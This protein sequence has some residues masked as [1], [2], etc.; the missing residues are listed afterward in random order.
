[1]QTIGKA[2]NKMD[3]PLN[4]TDI[5]LKSISGKTNYTIDVKIGTKRIAS[6]QDLRDITKKRRKQSNPTRISSNEENTKN[7]SDK[8]ISLSTKNKSELN[9]SEEATDLKL[10]Y[11]QYP[12]ASLPLN[13][14]ITENQKFSPIEIQNIHFS[15]DI[16]LKNNSSTEISNNPNSLQGTFLKEISHNYKKDYST[17]SLTCMM[18]FSKNQ[19]CS[20]GTNVGP[21]SVQIFN[22]EAFCDQCNKEFCNKYFL[23]THKANKHGVFSDGHSNS[24]SLD[25][26]D[27]IK[28][29]TLPSTCDFSSNVNDN[30]IGASTSSMFK[31]PVLFSQSSVNQST[32]V[33]KNIFNNQTRAF[34]SICQKEFCNKYFVRRHKA[35]IHGIADD[36]DLK[37]TDD[38]PLNFKTNLQ[39]KNEVLDSGVS[40]SCDKDVK[41]VSPSFH[42]NESIAEIS[43]THE[44][45]FFKDIQT[46]VDNENEIVMNYAAVKTQHN[47]I[48]VENTN[49]ERNVN[50]I[51]KLNN[52]LCNITDLHSIEFT[53]NSS[54][55]TNTNIHYEK[56][57]FKNDCSK[58]NTKGVNQQS[59]EFKTN[60]NTPINLVTNN[61][62]NDNI[63]GNKVN[64]LNNYLPIT[65]TTNENENKTNT[66]VETDES[67]IDLMSKNKLLTLHNLFF[68]LD[69]NTLENMSTCYVCNMKVDGS[70][71]AHIFNEHEKIVHELMNETLESNENIRVE[72]SCHECHQIF[73]SDTLLK[74]HIEQCECNIKCMGR[75]SASSKNSA[76]NEEYINQ[77]VKDLGERKQTTMLSSFCKICN[78]E[79]CNKYFMKTHMQRMHGISIQNGN[80]IGG[81]VCDI[82]NKELCSKYFLRVH[83]QNSHGIVENGSCQK[84]WSDSMT[85]NGQLSDETENGHRYYK[86]YTEVCNI[87]LRRFRSSKWLSAHLLNDHGSEG[88]FQW[89]HI[90]NHLEEE[91]QNL[92]FN[93]ELNTNLIAIGSPK[94]NPV[95]EQIIC[96]EM[97]QYRCSYCSF[98][99]SILSFLFVHE[100][101]HLT[102]NK[103]TKDMSL[104]CP[105]CSVAFQNKTK[106]E[107]H[108][109]HCHINS[110]AKNSPVPYATLHSPDNTNVTL[111]ANE[112]SSTDKS[113]D[114]NGNDVFADKL[115]T[116][117]KPRQTEDTSPSTEKKHNIPESNHEPF[118]MQSFFLENCSVSPSVKKEM[119]GRSDSFHSSLVYL[120]VKEKLTSTVNVFF[121]LTPT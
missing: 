118:I 28:I 117:I 1:M 74:E 98:T 20:S 39:I 110:D 40:D 81:V 112:D 89:K 46:S 27:K 54:H 109:T 58:S 71:K 16:Q 42:A 37:L 43:K 84:Y 31:N 6:N 114:N 88:K 5:L 91:K 18:P 60:T 13:L 19:P 8:K 52:E 45:L 49:D 25:Q 38:I 56:E 90:Q 7:R 15:N 86:H 111:N 68:K 120:P 61:S 33:S 47:N 119:S 77:H 94:Q 4:W 55:I 34:C 14:T 67:K 57:V 116:S 82:C 64:I 95:E 92:Q 70:L 35:K 10:T 76:E 51:N 96:D 80:H 50:Y 3:F 59:T 103:T 97:K 72:H 83:K 44:K 99:T 22:P 66:N 108:F 65:V 2:D 21:T 101:F 24:S 12:S 104:T 9:N 107:N 32:Y 85:E 93:C 121:K 17:E 78:K 69:G 115:E 79:L 23:K 41:T 75:A 53:S 48:K 73:N 106:L 63:N 36:G 29:T 102:E 26:L 30:N 100:K 105:T 11:S 113:L 87:C 62:V